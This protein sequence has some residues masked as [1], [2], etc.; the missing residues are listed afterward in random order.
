MS[1][2]KEKKGMEAD[3]C[4]FTK[5]AFINHV[6]MPGEGAYQMSILLHKP[7][8][9]KIFHKGGRVKMSNYLF[10]WFMNDPLNEKELVNFYSRP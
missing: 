9:V 5:G 8:Q 10:T 4:Y 3:V 7:Y 1:R 2:R 6:D